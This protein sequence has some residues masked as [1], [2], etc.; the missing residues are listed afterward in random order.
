MPV[1]RKEASQTAGRI[2]HT[3]LLQKPRQSAV[4]PRFPV[5]QDIHTL[6]KL[7]YE[8]YRA[9]GRPATL[10][11]M[12]YACCPGLED[13]GVGWRGFC[14]GSSTEQVSRSGVVRMWRDPRRALGVSFSK[15][16]PFR[17]VRSNMSVPTRLLPIGNPEDVHGPAGVHRLSAA[18]EKYRWGKYPPEERAVTPPCSSRCTSTRL[19]TIWCSTFLDGS[20]NTNR[21]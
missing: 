19:L 6:F 15:K 2:G 17:P 9:G 14:F 1:Q 5:Q 16:P 13:G 21:K 12:P 3:C 7:H 4:L 20:G 10:M 11:M 8:G 18:W